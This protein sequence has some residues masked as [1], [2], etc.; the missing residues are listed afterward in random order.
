MSDYNILILLDPPKLTTNVRTVIGVKIIEV[1]LECLSIANP[2]AS[3]FWLDND[4][5][6]ITDY[7]FYTIKTDNQSSI[8]SFSIS[9]PETSELLFYC[10]SN[11]SIGTTEKSINIS[12][13]KILL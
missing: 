7:Q 9:L 6:E 4:Q 3:I 5:Q 8:L 12:G 11:N 2:L 13:K 1:F 10:Y